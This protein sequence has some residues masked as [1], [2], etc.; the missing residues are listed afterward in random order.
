MLRLEE[1]YSYAEK[2]QQK[3]TKKTKHYCYKQFNN[4]PWIKYISRLCSVIMDPTIKYLVHNPPSLRHLCACRIRQSISY[5][6]QNVERNLIEK[7]TAG[8]MMI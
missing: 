4:L 5:L 7:L 2:T 6:G 3:R 1:L 8:D